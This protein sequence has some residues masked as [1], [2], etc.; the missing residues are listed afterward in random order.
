MEKKLKVAFCEKKEILTGKNET[1]IRNFCN[2]D[3]FVRFSIL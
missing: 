3:H 1:F 2:L